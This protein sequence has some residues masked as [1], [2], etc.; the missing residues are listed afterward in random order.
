MKSCLE[1]CTESVAPSSLAGH[2]FLLAGLV[3]GS[4][5]VQLAAPGLDAEHTDDSASTN[6]SILSD[7][8]LYL[9]QDDL[10]SVVSF[11]SK[12]ALLE[13]VL[14]VVRRLEEC[15]VSLQSKSTA[16]LPTEKTAQE[17]QE[18]T[19][20]EMNRSASVVLLSDIQVS[21]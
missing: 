2:L 8:V 6:A 4:S 13:C 16:E 9:S 11:G 15:V 12:A 14:V 10:L 5:V 17:I 18:A 21:L 3:R 20:I 1:R 7:I 19:A